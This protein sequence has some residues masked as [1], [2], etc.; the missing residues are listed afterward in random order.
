[1]E[2]PMFD[3]TQDNSNHPIRVWAR[4]RPKLALSALIAG[5]VVF[6]ALFLANTH[7]PGVPM[8]TPG[9]KSAPLSQAALDRVMGP[10]Q[11]ALS[12]ARSSAATRQADA[13]G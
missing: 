7:R 9:Q 13:N 6:L 11:S 12:W 1:M 10:I 3:T 8:I 2:T 4:R 5:S